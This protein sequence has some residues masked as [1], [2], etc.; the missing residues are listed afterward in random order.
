[1]NDQKG[2]QIIKNADFDVRPKP[3][4]AFSALVGVLR[5]GRPYHQH[6]FSEN[7]SA[8]F[9]ILPKKKSAHRLD[10]TPESGTPE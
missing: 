10:E 7:Y 2:F 1:M 6:G 4:L 3:I 8:D 9:D 5:L